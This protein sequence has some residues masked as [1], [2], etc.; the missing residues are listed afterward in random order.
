MADNKSNPKGKNKITKI[1]LYMKKKMTIVF[2]GILVLLAAL[3][4]RIIYLNQLQ[5]DYY[6]QKVLEQ[7]EY[8]SRTLAYKR[9]SILDRNGTV[10]A[11]SEDVYNV[12]LDCYVINKLDDK[13]K[14]TA[15]EKIT[16]YIP[17]ITRESIIEALTN[18]PDS[19]YYILAKSLPFSQIEGL[20][21]EMDN[22]EELKGVWLEKGYKRSYPYSTLASSLLG[23]TFS[24]NVGNGGI[25]GEYNDILNGENGR[26]YG[27][28]NEDSNA[29]RTV[30]KP[31]DGYNV[32]STI[33]VNIQ[34]IVEKYMKQL[35]DELTNGYTEGPGCQN[36]GVIVMDPNTSEVLAMSDYP[37]FDLNNPKNLSAIMGEES[38]N[39]LTEEEYQ[40]KLDNIWNNY[41]ISSTYEPG[42]TFKLFTLASGLETGKLTGNETYVCD[43]YQEVSGKK[44]H[45]VNRS[46]HGT[47]TTADAIS[48][49][50]NDALMQMASI[51]GIDIFSKYQTIFNFGLKTTIDLPGEASTA[52][53]IHSAEE[54]IPMDLATYSFG[55]SFNTTMIQIASAYCSIINGGNYYQPHVVKKLVDSNGDTVK[56]IEPTL[57]KQTVTK[58]TCEKLMSYMLTTVET[59]TAKAAKVNGYSVGGKTGTAEKGDRTEAKY[60]VSF[61]GYAPATDPKVLIYVVIDEPNVERQDHAASLASTLAKNV[62]TEILPYMGVSPDREIEAEPEVP[63]EPEAP[64]EPQADPEND[65][66]LPLVE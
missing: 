17:D 40:N 8:N 18:S 19:K 10:L 61:A 32:V 59:G 30:I 35:N 4:I 46:G 45:C 64:Q 16:K 66:Q 1:T 31:T 33:D 39:S 42:S 58:E 38:A 3:I 47:E 7:Q 41:C 25:E 6:T 50:C 62:F 36:M 24:G 12:V 37:N 22:S 43:G 44:I 29:Q 27:Y 63:Q 9:G 21:E 2:S 49:S 34:E 56:T 15:I 14:E 28:I 54:M 51:I 20:Q 55:Q 53:L 65:P 57:M 11:V 5:G 26:E 52:S 48:N 60:V 13:Y 23:F